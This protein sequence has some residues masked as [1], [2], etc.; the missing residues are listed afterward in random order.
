MSFVSL[1]IHQPFKKDFFYHTLD[2]IL[3]ASLAHPGRIFSAKNI[4]KAFPK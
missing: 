1:S 2:A 3:K 4:Q